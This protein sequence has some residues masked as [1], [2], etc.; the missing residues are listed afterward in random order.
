MQECVHC[1]RPALKGILESVVS[2]ESLLAWANRLQDRVE[3]V[4]IENATRIARS[5]DTD[6][7][8]VLSPTHQSQIPRVPEPSMWI[9]KIALSRPYTF[10]VLSAG[11]V[12][13][14]GMPSQLL[15]R[16]PD[17]IAAERS[18]AAA[19][20]QIGVAKAA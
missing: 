18:L 19:S 2:V 12:I 17:I 9:V 6:A 3:Y 11:P 20:A 7:T 1:L 13:P 10:I 15:E 16:R 14:A 4:I 8:G 5:C